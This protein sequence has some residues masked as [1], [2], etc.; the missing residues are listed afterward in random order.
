MQSLKYAE[1]KMRQ[2]R[3]MRVT[4]EELGQYDE[5]QQALYE[6]KMQRI[7]AYIAQWKD[8][9]AVTELKAESVGESE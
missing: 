8:P 7:A 3:E 6:N 2:E 4:M 5:E 9:V 1:R